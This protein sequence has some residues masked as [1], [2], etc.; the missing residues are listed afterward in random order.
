MGHHSP[1]VYS[2]IAE[3]YGYRIVA[4]FA[5]N[6]GELRS[7]GSERVIPTAFA[8]LTVHFSHGSA[9]PIRIGL[10]VL[11][12]Y[13]LRTNVPLTEWVALVAAYRNY[14]LTGD[15]YL[16]AAQGLAKVANSIVLSALFVVHGLFDSDVPQN[17]A[18]L[19]PKKR[20]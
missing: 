19:N 3:I 7:Y 17:A 2:R 5:G 15:G 10:Q 8:P 20:P 18:A 13:R 1:V 6:T 9:Q 4:S 12:C 11:Q 16:D 14:L